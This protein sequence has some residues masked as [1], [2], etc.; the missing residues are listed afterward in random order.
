MADGQDLSPAGVFELTPEAAGAELAKMTAD[1]KAQS[2]PPA[3]SPAST[4]LQEMFADEKTRAAYLGG[5]L[6]VV[7]EVEKL[8]NELIASGDYPPEM[9][10][11]TVDAVS[12]PSALPRA[13]YS[14]LFDGLREQGLPED[15]EQY[16]S[17]FRRGGARGSANTG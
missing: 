14:A 8:H 12:D 10:I 9:L 15:T 1:Y 6:A 11:E 2:T 17:R 5:N 4:R 3:T 7:R 16:I 13:A